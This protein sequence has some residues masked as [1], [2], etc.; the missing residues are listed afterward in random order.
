MASQLLDQTTTTDPTSNQTVCSSTRA[1]QRALICLLAL[2]R[3][4]DIQITNEGT[5]KVPRRYHEG[6]RSK[7]CTPAVRSTSQDVQLVLHVEAFR[8][9]HHMPRSDEY[10]P[11]YGYSKMVLKR[12]FEFFFSAVH[13]S[14]IALHLQ[15]F[16]WP[17]DDH[18]SPHTWPNT[19][20]K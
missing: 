2:S 15:T 1:F 12:Q 11:S 8:M 20:N 6:K 14:T 9:R 3:S 16:W 19:T 7:S 17:C 13:V 18:I 10:W 4:G 5:T